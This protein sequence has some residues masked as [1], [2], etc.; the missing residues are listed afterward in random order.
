MRISELSR[1]SGVPL[2][3]IKYYL[4]EGLLPPG[5]QTAPNQASYDEQHVRRLRLIRALVEVGRLGLADVRRV[6]QA[7]ADEAVPI[8]RAI[9]IAHRA[10][11]TSTPDRAADSDMAQAL[12]DVDDYLRNRRWQV[13]PDAP[14]RRALAGALDALRQL[15]RPASVDVLDPYADIADRL[16]KFELRATPDGTSR[17]ETIEFA[18]IGTV[19]FEAALVALRRLAQEHHSRRR[20]R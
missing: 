15:G 20:F 2:P 18:V 19:V 13:A 7:A 16:A 12:S 17:S 3:T 10:L 4:R 9:G 5:R 6:V 11:D 1:R 8:G 14:A